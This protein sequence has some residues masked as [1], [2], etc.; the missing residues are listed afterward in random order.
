MAESEDGQEKT[1][2]PTDER[3]K[4][5]RDRGDVA[6][7]KELTAVFVLV[8]VLGFLGF[9]SYHGFLL[10]KQLLIHT[11]TSV[12]YLQLTEKNIGVVTGDIWNSFLFISVPVCFVSAVAA[13]FFTLIQTRMNF[14]FQ[15]LEPKWSKINPIEGLKRIFSSQALM[16]LAKG[17][18]KMF[19]VFCVT[20]LIL[21]SEKSQVTGLLNIS[22][23]HSIEYW[24]KTT[25][26]LF[27][28][29]SIMLL[30]ISAADYIYNYRRLENQMRM[31]KQE[32][33]E[34]YKKR[35]VDPII[36]NR[37]RKLQRD[38]SSR[39]TIDATKTATVVITN[40][41]HYAVA[42]KYELGMIAPT[43]VAK[44]I[45][46]LALQMREAAK[47]ADVPIV[48]NKAL[49]RTIYKTMKIGDEVPESLYKAISEIIRYVFNI[50]GM[51]LPQ[52]K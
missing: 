41:T 21:Y 8:S 18:G 25:Q 34:D 12:S 9:S 27:W 38:L 39:K 4:E 5:F 13:I 32:V 19:A 1:E 26:I 23:I 11:L 36:K 20:F 49:A 30:I 37:M 33:K 3:R 22:I 16:E 6:Q 40:P 14:S 50:K 31:T 46:F 51:R 35:E 2:D 7:S 45:D 24:S 43:L 44:G 29:V 17:M 48:E 47:E 10:L 15:R 42:I 52:R 28:T